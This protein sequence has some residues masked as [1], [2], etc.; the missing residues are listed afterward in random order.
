MYEKRIEIRWRDMDALGHVNNAVYAT[1][2]EE[3][4]D[5]WVERA[6]GGHT[7]ITSFVL[8]RI[9]IDF[10]RELSQADD[11]VIARCGI[12][13]IGTSS[14]TMREE[15]RTLDGDLAAEGE[16]VVVARDPQA[17]RSRPLSEEERRMLGAH[18]IA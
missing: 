3:V 6:L 1:Y 16:T 7:P 12:V 9:A 13:R 2:F 8:A 14:F 17:G 11:A 15:I 5:E 18:L 4:R 10:R